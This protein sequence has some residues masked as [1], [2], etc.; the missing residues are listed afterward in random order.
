MPHRVV[1]DDDVLNLVSERAEPLV[2]SFNSAL[3]RI[4]GLPDTDQSPVF[5][6]IQ[7]I[8][9]I[10][11]V[12]SADDESR[13]VAELRESGRLGTRR[14]SSPRK[15]SR[16]APK[17]DR[18]PKGSLLDE[19]AY[20]Q[21]ILKVLAESPGGAAQARH[22]VQRVGEILADQLKP[23]DKETV[24]SGGLRWE[25]RIMFARLR[26]KDAGLLKMDS[27]RGLWELSDLGRQALTDGR[28][29]SAA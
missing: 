10:P 11:R 20:W 8:K 16:E 9:P 23:L 18:A 13:A 24:S 19:R 22:V 14:R 7:A 12:S 17:R 21:P 1:I 29:K 6:D 25:T 4:L 3:R 5:F 26:M 2:D 15:T 28:A 27:P